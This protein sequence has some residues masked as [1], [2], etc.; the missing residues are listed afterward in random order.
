MLDYKI[1]I[2][3]DEVDEMD[4]VVVLTKD[5]SYE[6]EYNLKI[7]INSIGTN[8]YIEKTGE[9]YVYY[10]THKIRRIDAIKK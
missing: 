5:V 3:L 10:P 4:N 9:N 1:M 7:D 8:G 6:K 2:Y